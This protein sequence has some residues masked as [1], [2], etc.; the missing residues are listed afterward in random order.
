LFSSDIVAGI[1]QDDARVRSTRQTLIGEQQLPDGRTLLSH[2]RIIEIDGASLLIGAAMDVTEWKRADA[3]M[4]S[5]HH[6]LELIAGGGEL[7]VI[8]DALCK[9]M[10]THLFGALCSVLLLDG[11]GRHLRGGAAPSLP[12]AYSRAIDGLAIGPLAGSC[13]A[14]AFLGEQVIVEDIA[15]SPLWVDYLAFAEQHGLY[16]CW[17]TPIFSAT[18]QVLGTFAVYYRRPKRPGDNE[19]LVISHATRLAAVAIERWQQ[20]SELRRLATTDPLTGLG[21]RAHFIDRA[22]AELRRADRFNRDLAVLMV[23]I[24]FF[25]K[26]NDKH[27]HAAGDEALRVFS[28]LLG[29][30]TRAVDLLGRIGGEEFAVLLPETGIGAALQIAERLRAAVEQAGFVFHHSEPIRFTI[31]IG[32]SLLQ[33]GDNLDSILARADGALYRAKHAGRNRIERG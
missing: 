12:L 11:D 25:K 28:R 6:V 13:G 1:E 14:A 26:I 31:S 30:E 21:N 5:G 22:E 10:E 19:L 23:D 20:V 7:P 9:R 27:G 3:L 4:V 8:L 18:R 17:S 32:A 15:N 2:K 33:A 29:K 16:A 24:D